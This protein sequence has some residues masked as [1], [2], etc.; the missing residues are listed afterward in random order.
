MQILE[1]INSSKNILVVTQQ[2]PDFASLL[3]ANF[4]V[5]YL[6]S[7]A[8]N[9]NWLLDKTKLS[10]EFQKLVSRENSHLITTIRSNNFET[11]IPKNSGV[12]DIVIEE[13]EQ[14]F[15]LIF[16]TANGQLKLNGMEIQALKLEFDLIILLTNPEFNTVIKTFELE[17]TK[18]KQYFVQSNYKDSLAYTFAKNWMEK[19]ESLTPEQATVLLTAILWESTDNHN[20]SELELI[21]WLIFRCKADFEKARTIINNFKLE[22]VSDWKTAVYE[23]LKVTPEIAYSVITSLSIDAEDILNLPSIDKIPFYNGFEKNN[24]AVITETTNGTVIFADG[25]NLE[26]FNSIEADSLNV[27]S[28]ILSVQTKL[29]VSEILDLLEIEKSLEGD[30]KEFEVDQAEDIKEEESREEKE[31]STLVPEIVPEKETLL[32]SPKSNSEEVS[33]ESAQSPEKSEVKID[34]KT[35]IKPEKKLEKIIE[36]PKNRNT[37]VLNQQKAEKVSK[38]FVTT[39]APEPAKTYDPLPPADW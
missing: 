37:S 19:R 5:D 9:V 27:N 10:P 25:N 26:R 14:G 11:V 24:L 6:F 16:K 3:C 39:K 36:K 28:G 31:E 33:Q 35:E 13:K 8:K 17:Q 2:Q 7:R 23:N 22:T 38:Q 20:L 29:G 30:S 21:N 15:K 18:A 34:K 12:E 32:E 4:L 1:L